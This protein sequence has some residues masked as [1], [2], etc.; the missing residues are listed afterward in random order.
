MLKGL[1]AGVERTVR[2][3]DGSLIHVRDDEYVGRAISYFGDLD[4]KITWVC[5][6]LLQPSDLFIDVGANY[7]VVTLQAAK[8]VGPSGRVHAIE[9]QPR[10]AAR[11]RESAVDNGYSQVHV[12]EVALSAENGSMEMFVPQANTGAASLTR[13]DEIPGIT[14][15]VAVRDAGEFL[16]E[17][18][19]GGTARLVKLDVE[20]HEAAVLTAGADYFAQSPPEGI[21]F[22]S[23]ERAVPF[24]K[25]ETTQILRDMGYTLHEL[26]LRNVL[27]PVVREIRPGDDVRAHDFL[28][29]RGRRV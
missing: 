20:G 17:I 6:Q 25:R 24:W 2:L 29:L 18:S 12:H 8:L 3:R 16:D 21:L 9:P 23:N 15:Q 11:L 5:R 10:M 22:E 13:H 14:I 28:G 19:A 27:R 7:G 4:R 26:S 1:S